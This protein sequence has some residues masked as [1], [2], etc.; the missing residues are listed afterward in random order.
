M[1]SDLVYDAIRDYLEANWTETPIQFE[2]ENFDIPESR[3]WVIFE[4]TGTVYG[5]QSIGADNQADNRWDE[6]GVMWLHVMAQAGSGSSVTRRRCKALADLF[7]GKRLIYDTLEFMDADIGMGAQG[8]DEGS[9][10]RISVSI[11]WRREEA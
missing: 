11:D 10:Y 5:Q 1:A 8:D 7:R 2:N 6:E 3:A 4:M 9:T